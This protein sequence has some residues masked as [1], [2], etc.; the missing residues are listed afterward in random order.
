MSTIAFLGLGRMGWPMA[1]NLVARGHQVTVWNRTASTAEAFAAE[2]RAATAPTPGEAVQSAEFVVS[3]LADDAALLDAYLGND[4]VIETLPD[5]AVCVDMATVS[6]GTVA[7]LHDL[8]AE[9]GSSFVDAPVSGSVAA[10]TAASLTI[11]AAGEP[12]AVERARS[13][14]DHLGAPVIAMGPRGAGCAMKLVV[15]AIL[16]SLN[17]AVSEALVLAERAGIERTDAYA[18]LVESAV[19]A[20][21][22]QYRRASFE[23]PDESPVAFRLDLAAKDIRLA[24]ALAADVGADLPQARTNLD[25]L[26]RAVDAG[27]E[28]RD[29]TALAEYLRLADRPLG[30]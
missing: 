13:V 5:D 26:T 4:G 27:F 24:L 1:A 18:V 11:M 10:A 28:D 19:A 12:D 8:V 29:E 21:F 14:L 30:D 2:H 15:N 9:R 23:R 25:V 3:M 7:R 6:P 22:V 20:P 17:G 16:H